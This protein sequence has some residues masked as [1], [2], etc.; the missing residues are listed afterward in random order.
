MGSE[1]CIRDRL[2]VDDRQPDEPLVATE[3]VTTSLSSGGNG[4]EEVRNLDKLMRENPC[5]KFHN[6]QRGY[7]RCTVT[8]KTWTSD[9]MVCDDVI[10]PGGKTNVKKSLV[11]EA[12]NPAIENA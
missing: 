2:R 3:F 12:G 9:Y 11:V 1:M 5:V 10:R 8:P 6:Q 4:P 7:V